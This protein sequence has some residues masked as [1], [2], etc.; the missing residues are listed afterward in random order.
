MPSLQDILQKI[1]SAL[2]NLQN[3][4]SPIL[5]NLSNVLGSIASKMTQQL[6]TGQQG[7]PAPPSSGFGK[8]LFNAL[9]TGNLQQK[10]A[11]FSGIFKAAGLSGIGNTLGTA[12]KIAGA[13]AG[14]PASILALAKET[15]TSIKDAS[16]HMQNAG[17]HVAAS[18]TTQRAERLGSNAFGAMQEL[19]KMFGPLGIANQALGAFGKL[20]FD[21]IEKLRNWNE[22]LYKANVQFAEFSGAMAGVQARQDVRQLLLD[23]ERGDRRA[24]TAELQAREKHGFNQRLAPIEDGLANFQNIVS[25][26]VNKAN[27]K[28]FDALTLNAFKPS[29]EPKLTQ[30][31]D[32]Q[33]NTDYVESL[34]RNYG[35]PQ[36]FKRP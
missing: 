22:N 33:E 26:G 14:D 18:F 32:L 2:T 5:T 28:I 11:A 10:T 31:E 8:F 12:T 20:V 21:S 25:A 34:F 19:G 1:D 3:K 13:V 30:L 24:E 17:K 15:I 6:P 23:K 9:T 29:D 4:S 35:V 27:S 16:V 7:P 36:R